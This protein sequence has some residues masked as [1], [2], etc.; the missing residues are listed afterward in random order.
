MLAAEFSWRMSAKITFPYPSTKKQVY[1]IPKGIYF[2]YNNTKRALGFHGN[3]L[4]VRRYFH[5]RCVQTHSFFILKKNF[6]CFGLSCLDLFLQQVGLFCRLPTVGGWFGMA[7]GWAA[8]AQAAFYCCA[9]SH[10][11]GL[12]AEKGNVTPW[13]SQ[14][15][16]SLG[17]SL[18]RPEEPQITLPLGKSLEA[19][20]H[21]AILGSFSIF[22]LKLDSP[23]LVSQG[24]NYIIKA[25]NLI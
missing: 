6:S 25:S 8:R 23:E 10:A 18:H 20:N 22:W 4:E 11:T 14:P 24:L 9:L 12:A 1:S 3:I 7:A 2:H 19:Q 17:N 21:K 15:Q 16:P 5:L 13:L